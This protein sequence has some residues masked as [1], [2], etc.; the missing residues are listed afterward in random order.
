MKIKEI[1]L[2]YLK[3]TKITRIRA[4]ISKKFLPT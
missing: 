3:N 2:V 4:E 1:V